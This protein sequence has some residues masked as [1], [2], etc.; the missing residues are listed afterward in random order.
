M[1]VKVQGVDNLSR[2]LTAAAADL[3][4][5][6]ETNTA[7]G[8]LLATRAAARAPRRTG[9]LAASVRATPDRTGVQVGSSLIYGPPIHWGWPARHVRRQPFLTDTLTD[10]APAVLDLYA[11]EVNRVL[12]NVKGI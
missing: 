9:R 1:S 7:A 3:A 11:T 8:R 12:G 10:Q 5:L 6:G 2:T 4:D